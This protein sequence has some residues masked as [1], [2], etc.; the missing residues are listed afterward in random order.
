MQ[1]NSPRLKLKAQKKTPTPDNLKSFS[2]VAK[3]DKSITQS[4]LF[5]SKN[6]FPQTALLHHRNPKDVINTQDRV[7]HILHHN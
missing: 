6:V 1:G 4:E 2:F 7:P 3:S 5:S